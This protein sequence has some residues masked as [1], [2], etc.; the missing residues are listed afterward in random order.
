MTSKVKHKHMFSILLAMILLLI[1]GLLTL[2]KLTQTY[3]VKSQKTNPQSQQQSQLQF[4]FYHRLTNN[5]PSSHLAS[6]HA[7]TQATN[8]SIANDLQTTP[9]YYLQLASFKLKQRAKLLQS[10]LLK[11]NIP[12]FISSNNNQWYRVTAGPFNTKN[13]MKYTLNISKNY[14]LKPIMK[15]KTT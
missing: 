11:L 15:K 1:I 2:F 4:D 12:T 8:D 5:K 7:T 3:K 13:D 10:K 6:I 14:K 9:Q